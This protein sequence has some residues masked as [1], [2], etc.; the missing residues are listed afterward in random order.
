MVLI[1]RRHRSLGSLTRVPVRRILGPGQNIV[2]PEGPT[3]FVA[4]VD[5]DAV[6]KWRRRPIWL[7]HIGSGHRDREVVLLLR[8]SVAE[9]SITV[10]KERGALSIGR[11]GTNFRGG[12]HSSRP[13]LCDCHKGPDG[14][15]LHYRLARYENPA[16]HLVVRARFLADLDPLL[17]AGADVVVQEELETSGQRFS[18][19]LRT[20]SMPQ[21]EIEERVRALR[22]S[23]MNSS[24]WR[25]RRPSPLAPGTHRTGGLPPNDSRD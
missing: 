13:T 19:I 6:E 4:V 9:V 15:P 12:R 2:D 14:D 17:E 21:Y 1:G 20:Y 10:G 5:L 3:L 8:S 24:G 7:P 11:S 23:T 25:G 16:V 18:R 22:A